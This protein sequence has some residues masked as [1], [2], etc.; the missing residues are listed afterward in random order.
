MKRNQ[1]VSDFGTNISNGVTYANQHCTMYV[2]VGGPINMLAANK[3]SSMIAVAG[4]TILKIYS[5]D[6]TCFK[7]KINLR[8]GRRQGLNLSCADVA[9]NHLNESLIATAATNGAIIAWDLSASG[10]NKQLEIFTDHKRTV[11]KVC[12]HSSEPGRLLSGSQD[13]TMKMFDMRKKECIASFSSKT[14]GVR[15]V[16]FSPHEYFQFAASFDNG[17][18]QVWDYRN[19]SSCLMQFIAHKGSVYSIDWHPDAKDKQ[20]IATGGRDNKVKIWDMIDHKMSEHMVIPTNSLVAM[21]RWRTQRRE[22]I[23]SV[24]MMLDHSINVWDMRRPYMPFA[25]FT[26]HTDVTTGIAWKKNDPEILF[27]CS[28]DGTLYQ[29]SIRDA[30]RPS[31]HCNISGLSVSARGYIGHASTDSTNSYDAIPSTKTKG[32]TRFGFRTVVGV[33]PKLDT[34]S[35]VQNTLSTSSMNIKF[36]RFLNAKSELGIHSITPIKEDD[37]PTSSDVHPSS[38]IKAAQQYKLQGMAFN[39]LCLHN[40]KVCDDLQMSIDANIWRYLERFFEGVSTKKTERSN[41]TTF[42]TNSAEISS[43]KTGRESMKNGIV[44][45]ESNGEES[46]QHSDPETEHYLTDIAKG[47]AT[48]EQECYYSDEYD[49]SEDFGKGHH[50]GISSGPEGYMDQDWYPLSDTISDATLPSEAFKQ[51]LVLTA[52]DG[53]ENQLDP[54]ISGEE[55]KLITAVPVMIPSST[56]QQNHNPEKW[57]K[58]NNSRSSGPSAVSLHSQSS[59]PHEQL[60]VSPVVYTRPYEN[61]ALSI[62]RKTELLSSMYESMISNGNNIQIITCTMIVLGHY[63]P[64][65]SLPI[66]DHLLEHWQNSY[67]E[68]VSRY[69]L[70]N[71]F[72]EIINLSTLPSIKN[73]NTSSTLN[74][75]CGICH[76]RMPTANPW[77][78]SKHS[79]NDH[80]QAGMGAGIKCSLCQLVVKSLYTWCQGCCHGGHIDCM[81]DWF[82]Y[83]HSKG[84]C[85]TGC[86]HICA[87]SRHRLPVK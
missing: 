34:N 8:V 87:S 79:D 62:S 44:T 85:P 59:S 61:P 82:N 55:E 23:A 35:W 27:S 57:R 15:C 53:F 86:G 51:R 69:E 33:A 32:M 18:V 60:S 72:T 36:A 6:D 4:R 17:S 28:K 25:H 70:W 19:T 78:C 11:T 38:L 30:H 43:L 65:I 71:H 26:E 29:H 80:K 20:R 22:Q 40:A 75:C 24:A 41:S 73:M 63:Y 10:R 56:S 66:D 46:E 9:W 7:E 3:D 12:F 37:F 2:D 83:P 21:A 58:K 1:I 14:D 50:G 49:L 16:Q 48:S 68:L 84:R 67:L 74:T 77:S 39:K 31:E 13:C 45:G 64:S 54:A 81:K 42:H 52:T 76:K 47:H 5:V